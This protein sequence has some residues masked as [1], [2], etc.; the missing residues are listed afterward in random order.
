[1]YLAVF[2]LQNAIDGGALSWRA[3]RAWVAVAALT[4]AAAALR[5]VTLGHQSL[6]YDEGSTAYLVGLSPG[7]M[8]GAIPQSES[9]PPLFFLVTWVWVHVFGHGDAALRAIPALA[10][11]AL[12]PVTFGVARRLADARVGV[13][14][15]AL[16]AVNPML[17]W[18]GQEARAYALLALFSAGALWCFVVALETPSRN[19]LAGWALLS[20][21]ALA[22]HYF[23]VFAWLPEAVWLLARH[24]RLAA[25]W[26]ASAAVAVVGLG[27][28]ALAAAQQGHGNPNWIGSIALGPRLGPAWGQFLFGFPGVSQLLLGLGALTATL[29]A[30]ALALRATDAERHAAAVGAT[31][32]LAA[33]ALPLVL[34]IVGL[35]YVLA[36]NLI[37]AV[38]PLLIALAAPLASRGAGR[39]GIGAL[40]VLL[41]A[42]VASSVAVFTNARLQRPAWRTVAAQLGAGIAGPR[43][44]VI[45]RYHFALP[46][47]HYLTNTWWMPARGAR[48]EE[49]DVISSTWPAR[50][51]CWWGAACN[52]PRSIPPR[53]LGVPGFQLAGATVDGE[54]TITR[55]RAT[56]PVALNPDELVG[57]GR[58]VTRNAVLLQPTK[59]GTPPPH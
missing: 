45:D 31:I 6:W 10:T 24:R 49:V 23:A 59:V 27:L 5:F 16:V 26:L 44:I 22:T 34:A 19:V 8:L 40:T 41:V 1:M 43:A 36:R 20:M 17:V 25:T 3:N 50:T 11:T 33:V 37:V 38:V 18:Y 12:V 29:L 56:A 53:A 28:V 52:I 46:L 2:G 47:G 30:C 39:L 57:G 48:V 58:G 15:A 51:A 42:G 54:F 21:L 4:A 9:T 7:R 13:A 14:A 55:F 35:D 32:A